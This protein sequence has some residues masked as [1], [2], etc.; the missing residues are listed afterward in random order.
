ME[1][2][3]CCVSAAAAMFADAVM[4]G[5][6]TTAV[7]PAEAVA[8]R[9]A[10]ALELLLLTAVAAV[11]ALRPSGETEA[12]ATPL[13]GW[14]NPSAPASSLLRRRAIGT[15]SSFSQPPLLLPA[16]ALAAAAAASSRAFWA[17]SSTF[18]RPRTA[19]SSMWLSMMS[20]SSLFIKLEI[21]CLTS[22]R[23]GTARWWSRRLMRC[24]W[25]RII[26]VVAIGCC[27]AATLS[28]FAP[29]DCRLCWCDCWWPSG[30]RLRPAPNP[31]ECCCCC[32]CWPPLLTL[33]GPP[34]RWVGVCGIAISSSR[35][36]PNDATLGIALLPPIIKGRRVLALLPSAIGV[37]TAG[38]RRAGESDCE[39]GCDD[40]E[41]CE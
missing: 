2:A 12:D 22:S 27:C 35:P 28:K 37:G 30:G 40:A 4:G 15:K 21:L 25:R 32:C 9:T 39:W 26:S 29:I 34:P 13:E 33:S 6:A 10:S 23:G 8:E 17:C 14:D 41:W 7:C 31:R 16:L 18:R 19:N 36:A 20:I 24:R 11:A 1:A 5:T 3:C 38:G